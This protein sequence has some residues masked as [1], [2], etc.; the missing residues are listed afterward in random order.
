VSRVP[1]LLDRAI[2]QTDPMLEE[3]EMDVPLSPYNDESLDL[4]TGGYRILGRRSPCAV[5]RESYGSPEAG[6]NAAAQPNIAAGGP[7]DIM[8]A[9]AGGM[10]YPERGANK[11]R[12]GNLAGARQK[13]T[14]G[15]LNQGRGV[16]G[17]GGTAARPPVNA[18]RYITVPVDSKR[19][20]LW[21]TETGDW[22]VSPR[23]HPKPP[24]SRSRQRPQGR[25]A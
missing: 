5:G 2:Y 3:D 23:R 6:V 14:S 13:R 16:P 25:L 15:N 20:G 11:T 17:A 8:R 24:Q 7:T 21:D 22:A 1:R 4:P 12:R 10:G 9:L 18:K 19:K